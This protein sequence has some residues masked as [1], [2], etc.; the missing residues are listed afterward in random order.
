MSIARRLHYTYEDYLLLE[1]YSTIKH[2]YFDGEIFAM[3]GGTPEHAMLGGKAI[4]LLAS[5]LPAGCR[6]GSSD[7]KILV[8]ATGLATYPDAS[9]VCGPLQC[10]ANDPNALVNPRVLL[11]VTSKGTEEYDRGERLRQYKLIPSL[12]A[13]VF[14]SHRERRVTVHRRGADGWTEADAV[15]GGSAEVEPGVSLPVDELYSVVELPA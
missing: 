6:V 2:E 4:G 8:E 13:V 5:R 14:V 12:Q 7:L 15:A 3:A 10:A 1:Q 11:E 9:V